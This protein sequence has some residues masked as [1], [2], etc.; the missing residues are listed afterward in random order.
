MN[1]PTI[2]I[3]ALIGYLI[4]MTLMGFYFARKNVDT[5]EYFVG[6][7][8]YSGWVIGLSLVG[9]SIS[10]ITFLAYPGDA[11][12]TAWLRFTPNFML[13]IGVIIAAYVFLP[14]FRRGKITSAY[15]YLES[16]FGP[17]IRVY[18]ALAFILSQ[19]TRVSIILFLLS[20]VVEKMTGLNATACI[21]IGGGFVAMY[22]IVG[23]INAVIWTDVIQTVVLVLGGFL[24]LGVIV[25]ALPGGLTQIIEVASANNKF[26]LA[27]WSDGEVQ[28]VSWAFTLSDKTA[29]MMLILG[30][31]VWLTEYSGNQNVIQRYATSRDAKQARIA[32]FVC[33]GASVPIWAFYMFL[34]TSLYVYFQVFPID[35]ATAI[36]QGAEGTKAE[37]IL[38]LFIIDYL[39]PGITG[40]V[41]AAALAAA[42][43]SLDSSINAISTVGIVDIY[44]RHLVKDRDDKHYLRVAFA[45]ATAS[46]VIMISGAIILDQ[47]QMK[48]L[49]D[50]ATKLASILLAGL[51]GMYMLGFFT[52][53]GDSRAV[54]VGIVCTILF[55]IWT[56]L[57]ERGMLPDYLTVPF[58]LYYTGIIGNVVMFVV[59]FLVASLLPRRERSLHNLT[60]WTQDNTP[61]D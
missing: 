61:L 49:Q 44:R 36:L 47:V 28:P 31:T 55:T 19:L 45:L 58:D 15:Q 16:R 57:A 46:A 37:H 51:L 27:E 42:M 32:M 56:I 34:G 24:C 52:T 59:G 60:V 23:G 40:I 10:S 35:E 8:S 53:R 38:P 9:T 11:F 48:T 20:M 33:A 1:L 22:T 14:F 50:A 39:P 30:L 29:T 41:I 26:A 5:E 54:G 13:P 18:A 25:D 12:K 2:D 17:G 6:G 43:S 3:I 4:G 7:R 21:L